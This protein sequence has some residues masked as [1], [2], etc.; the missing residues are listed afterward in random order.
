MVKFA[1]TRPK[2]LCRKEW[3]LWQFS[4][5]L[6]YWFLWEYVYTYI[7]VRVYVYMCSCVFACVPL[8]SYMPNSRPLPFN[9]I[10]NRLYCER[11]HEGWLVG[12]FLHSSVDYRVRSLFLGSSVSVWSTKIGGGN[13]K[14]AFPAWVEG[15]DHGCGVVGSSL[16]SLLLNALEP[17][18]LKTLHRALWGNSWLSED[19]L[20]LTRLK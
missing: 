9:G 12:S 17:A 4:P 3:L 16:L 18:W 11:V 14:N 7:G 2:K 1:L 15:W 5:T 13:G 20:G 19:A 6:E 8:R 10:R